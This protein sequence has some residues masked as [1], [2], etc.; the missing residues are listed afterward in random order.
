MAMECIDGRV[1]LHP[2]IYI[3]VYMHTYVYVHM[4]RHM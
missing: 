3:L 2:H 4:R 1:Y